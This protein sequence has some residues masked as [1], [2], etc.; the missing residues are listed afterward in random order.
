[1]GYMTTPQFFATPALNEA[2]P[3]ADRVEIQTFDKDGNPMGSATLHGYV[4][5]EPIDVSLGNDTERYTVTLSCST[6]DIRP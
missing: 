1:M 3:Y 6:I 4:R 5:I 2:L